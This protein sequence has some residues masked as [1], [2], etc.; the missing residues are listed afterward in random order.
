[1]I[2]TTKVNSGNYT[3]MRK[4][5]D[6]YE[7]NDGRFGCNLTS[8]KLSRESKIFDKWKVYAVYTHK[9]MKSRDRFNYEV[10]MTYDF[11]WNK[12]HAILYY[13]T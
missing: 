7:V 11:L 2:E 6:A 1:M 9:D 13:L 5:Y 12:P 3:S 8:L 10:D 4:L